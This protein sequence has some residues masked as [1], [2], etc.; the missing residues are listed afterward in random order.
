ML[1]HLQLL[2]SQHYQVQEGIRFLAMKRQVLVQIFR[3]AYN[4]NNREVK[5]R[6]GHFVDDISPV[7]EFLLEW[8]TAWSSVKQ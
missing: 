3:V 7:N 4:N 5:S 8:T 2:N 6:L 1:L